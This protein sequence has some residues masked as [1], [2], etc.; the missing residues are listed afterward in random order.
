[1]PTGRP[2]VATQSV[3]SGPPKSSDR[4]PGQ[5]T[6][7]EEPASEAELPQQPP[8]FPTVT[9]SVMSP[10]NQGPAVFAHPVMSS[11]APRKCTVED[12]FWSYNDSLAFQG[13]VLA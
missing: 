7:L 12:P 4:R 9:Q 8:K 13:E 5:V 3:L 1:M 2:L 6:R 11:A 10:Q